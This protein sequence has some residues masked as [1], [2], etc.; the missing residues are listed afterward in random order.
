M[1]TLT[2]EGT[3]IIQPKGNTTTLLISLF[4]QSKSKQ[5][6]VNQILSEDKKMQPAITL[7]LYALITLLLAGWLDIF[8]P[9]YTWWAAIYHLGN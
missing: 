1:K 9:E 5:I 7:V 3:G 8:G 2:S 6:S 4:Q